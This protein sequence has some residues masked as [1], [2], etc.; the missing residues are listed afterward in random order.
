MNFVGIL[1]GI[2]V[3]AAIIYMLMKKRDDSS[4]KVLEPVKDSTT[5]PQDSTT[6]P[7]DSTTPPPGEV[8]APISVPPTPPAAPTISGQFVRLTWVNSHI[9]IGEVMVYNDKG[10]NLVN[11]ATTVVTSDGVNFRSSTEG[12]DKMFDGQPGSVAVATSSAPITFNFGSVQKIS[13]IFIYNNGGWVEDAAVRNLQNLATGLK[14]EILDADGNTVL[15]TSTPVS[16]G[17]A[18]YSY[19]PAFGMSAKMFDDQFTMRPSS[20][21]PTG[22]PLSARYIRLTY[23]IGSF[24]VAEFIVRANGKNVATAANTTTTSTPLNPLSNMFDQNLLTDYRA[25]TSMPVGPVVVDLGSMQPIEWI[26]L[27]NRW[28]DGVRD[29][30]NG[31][32]LELLNES[33]EVVWKS[34]PMANT[35]NAFRWYPYDGATTSAFPMDMTLVEQI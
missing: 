31:A 23:P 21:V 2:G 26:M 6:P 15:W 28:L 20:V 7:Q 4:V 29:R 14:V 27:V 13:K 33:S 17:A 32:V 22:T 12:I 16:T 10:E 19:E 8:T 11:P 5:P 18:A 35:A 30:I 9:R 34:D 3:V 24:G 25:D 1:I